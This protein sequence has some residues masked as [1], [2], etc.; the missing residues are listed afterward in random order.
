LRF[1]L[2]IFLSALLLFQVQPIIARFILPWYG[3]S[4]AVWTTCMLFF[5]TALLAGYAYAH[6]MATRLRLP[7][8]CVVHGALLLTSLAV[9]PITP[10]DAWKPEGASEPTVGILLLLAATVGLPYLVVATSAPL[11][12]SWFHQALPGRSPYR[13][14]AL[15]NL[16]SLLGLVSYPFV[17]EPVLGLRQ[18][19]EV[20]SAGYTVYLLVCAWCAA[21]LLRQRGSTPRD[22]AACEPA[23]PSSPPLD[24][25]LWVALPGAASTLLLAMTSHLCQDVAVVPFLWVLPLALYLLSFVIAFDSPRWYRRAVWLPFLAVTVGAVAWLLRQETADKEVALAAQVALYAGALF[26]SSLAAHGELARLKP[27]PGRLTSFYLLVAL[28]GALGGVF[29]SLVAPRLFAGNWELHGSLVAV[30]A[31]VGVS[32]L[33]SARPVV[34]RPFL[35]AG[36]LAWASAVVTLAVLLRAHARSRL[37]DSLAVRRSFYGVLRVAEYGEEERRHLTLFNGRISHGEQYSAPGYRQM[38][39]TYYGNESGIGV[40]VRNHARRLNGAP[41]EIGVIGLGVGT[42]AAHARPGDGVRFYEINPQVEELSR[43]YFTYL[44]DTQAGTEVILGDG[45]VSL[46]RELREGGP[47]RFDVLALDAFAGDAIPVHL[48]TREAFT[49]YWRH[50][51]PDGILAVHIT[52]RYLDLSDVVRVLAAELGK[53]A[54]WVEDP[55]EH[56]YT[57]SNDWCLVTENREFLDHPAVRARV[58]AWPR[59]EP[60]PVLWTDDYSNLL[61]VLIDDDDDEQDES[62]EDAEETGMEPTTERAGE[63]APPREEE[64]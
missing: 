57:D 8:Q 13:L 35:L 36:A 60:R 28:G 42:I 18:Q 39:T 16:G 58:T 30:P 37:E 26:A 64:G 51:E 2:A 47:R 49:I 6:A 55:D 63:D 7:A 40:A 62:G 15:S 53:E 61:D 44:S 3:G 4:P 5:Q 24:R 1:A 52:N 50:L 22:A 17:V 20:W 46:E 27:P 25:I 33:R 12:Q 56:F 34:R 38:P 32:V 59:A 41:L 45:R 11:L 9:L 19:T 31:L 21:L 23:A 29:V 54:V 10:H 48:L 43:R 14:Y